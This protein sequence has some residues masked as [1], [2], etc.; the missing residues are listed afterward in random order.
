MK[1]VWGEGLVHCFVLVTETLT[2]TRV[3]GYCNLSV[4]ESF[5]KIAGQ[6]TTLIE[7]PIREAVQPQQMQ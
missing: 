2:L 5:V 1:T 7:L 3:E 6:L 4:C